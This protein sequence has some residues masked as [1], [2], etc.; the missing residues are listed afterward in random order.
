MEEESSLTLDLDLSSIK[1]EVLSKAVEC[2]TRGLTHS[3]KWLSEI[4]YSIR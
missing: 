1:S 4:L 3:F 2:Q